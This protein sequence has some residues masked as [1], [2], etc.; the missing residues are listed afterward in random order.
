M[1]SS[2]LA[3]GFCTLK[4]M[5]GRRWRQIKL[6]AAPARS[7]RGAPLPYLP[8]GTAAPARPKD[9]HRASRGTHN[10]LIKTLTRDRL[11]MGRA[12]PRPGAPLSI[13]FT[14]PVDA[15]CLLAAQKSF[16][17]YMTSAG[18]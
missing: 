13:D 15:M 10:N 12:R 5:A 16:S 6:F 4:S 11:L 2:P 14:L 18:F 1:F 8:A 9:L 3:K 7:G 17:L